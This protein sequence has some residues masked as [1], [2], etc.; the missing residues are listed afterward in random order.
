M[1]PKP[2]ELRRGWLSRF[3]GG[4]DGGV[5]AVGTSAADGDSRG[6]AAWSLG[7]VGIARSSDYPEIDKITQKKL[8][9]IDEFIRDK[10]AL[11]QA[12]GF[13]DD[14]GSVKE[15]EASE[16]EEDINAIKASPE[17]EPEKLDNSKD[18][19]VVETKGDLMN[20]EDDAISSQDYG[21]KLA[22]ALFDGSILAAASAAPAS[23]SGWEAFK[24][25]SDWES[26]L[27]QSAS[28]MKKQRATVGGGFNLLLLDCMYQQGNTMVAM[29]SSVAFGSVGRP[30]ILALPAPPSSNHKGI[31]VV[32]PF[33]ASLAVEPLSY[34]QMSDMEKQWLLAVEQ[35]VWEQYRREGMPKVHNYPYSPV[36]S[37][38]HGHGSFG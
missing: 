14:F 30:A 20:L 28:Y 26:A 10:Y 23:V 21:D 11:E 12:K 16:E 32:D 1:S 31:N 3:F 25:D 37:P 22:L 17:P 19:V 7:S 4:F 6:D 36:Y 35:S 2:I 5:A 9:I 29:D 8:E 24:D 34:V 27:V 18:L 15:T 33:A 38:W 13:R